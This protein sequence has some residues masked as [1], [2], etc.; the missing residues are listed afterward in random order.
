MVESLVCGFVF[1]IAWRC[2]LIGLVFLLGGTEAAVN[3]FPYQ[4]A[5]FIYTNTDQSVC[6]GSILSTNFVLSAAHCF[7]SFVSSDLLA[8]LRNIELDTPV[9]ELEVF[10]TD[11]I[12]HAQYNR[13][14]QLNDIALVRTNRRPITFGA[15]IQALPLVPRSF[16]TTDLTGV[17]GRVAGWYKITMRLRTFLK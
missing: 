1:F 16:A 4:V 8:G 14:T 12:L 11:V 7:V 5:F 13:V 9:Y 17:V 10:P 2:K 3:Q 15:S 6:S